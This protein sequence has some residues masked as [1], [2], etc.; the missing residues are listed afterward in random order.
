[1]VAAIGLVA[2]LLQASLQDPQL[3]K[4][5]RAPKWLNIVG[6]LCALLSLFSDVLGIRPQ[7]ALALAFGAIAAFSISGTLIMHSM[8]KQRTG[9]K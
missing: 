5:L 7:V 8:R 1:V 3:S 9:P 2:L 6:I 4:H